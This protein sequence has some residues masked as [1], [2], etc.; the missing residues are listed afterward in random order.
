MISP[1]NTSQG[2]FLHI[3]FQIIWTHIIWTMAME[4]PAVNRGESGLDLGAFGQELAEILHVHD[5]VDHLP[6]YN[7]LE[8][9]LRELQI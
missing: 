6:G 1:Q 9:H 4:L 5:G 3:F 7:W 8:D 2:G